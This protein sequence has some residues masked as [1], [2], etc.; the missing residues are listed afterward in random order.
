MRLEGMT[1]IVVIRSAPV[2]PHL[3]DRSHRYRTCESGN[4]S[5]AFDETP[6]VRILMLCS[7]NRSR[8]PMASVLLSRHLGSLDAD[9]EVISAGTSSASC[10]AGAGMIIASK[11]AIAKLGIEPPPH[12]SRLLT[13]DLVLDADLVLAMAR[14]HLR[15]AVTLVPDAWLR[16]FTLKELVRRGR[17]WRPRHPEESIGEWLSCLGAGRVRAEALDDSPDDDVADP[18]GGP[19]AAHL[20][21][22]R[23]L[24][25]LTAEAAALIAGTAPPGRGSASSGPQRASSEPWLPC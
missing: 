15:E 16:T 17:A 3:S 8:S 13:P 20:R 19:I 1:A 6:A 24:D 23:E 5:D 11:N 18:T 9:A 4:P 25:D 10:V 21:T 12:R 7:A 14:E 22:A 2:I